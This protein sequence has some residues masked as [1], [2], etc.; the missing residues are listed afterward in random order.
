MKVSMFFWNKLAF[1][2]CSFGQIIEKRTAT[3]GFCS[4]SIVNPSKQ[5]WLKILKT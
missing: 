5:S 4:C 3:L 2:L 1:E